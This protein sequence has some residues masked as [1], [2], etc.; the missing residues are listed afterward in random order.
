[1]T[2]LRKLLCAGAIGLASANCNKPIQETPQM[3]EVDVGMPQL[4]FVK[5][6]MNEVGKGKFIEHGNLGSG[7]HQ[8]DYDINGMPFRLT[9]NTFYDGVNICARPIKSKGFYAAISFGTK[10][11][12]PEA[13][14]ANVTRRYTAGDSLTQKFAQEGCE[15]IERTYQNLNQNKYKIK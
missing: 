10:F 3:V 6:V 2:S 12:P 4:E 1:M 7:L 9:M 11:G 14:N 13:E 8:V 5:T 15:E